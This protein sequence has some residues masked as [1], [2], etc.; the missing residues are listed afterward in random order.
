MISKNSGNREQKFKKGG[1]LF[2]R[3]KTLMV[4]SYRY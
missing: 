3:N 2:L 1:I 4:L